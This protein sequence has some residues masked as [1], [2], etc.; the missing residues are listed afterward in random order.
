MLNSVE[1]AFRTLKSELNF[2]PVYHQIE[3]RAESHLFIAVLAY[4]IVNAILH[5][6]KENEI[7]I[8]W[9]TLRTMM[10]NHEAILTT[11]Q[12]KKGYTI[13]ILDGTEPED[14]HKEIYSALNLTCNPI[15][16]KETKHKLV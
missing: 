16:R 9:D 4:H 12:T 11:M 5:R 2:R 1:S 10:E 7:N 3:P 6:L 15:K 8:S 13:S 14:N